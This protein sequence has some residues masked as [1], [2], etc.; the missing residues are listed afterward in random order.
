[1]DKFTELTSLQYIKWLNYARR[2]LKIKEFKSNG[3]IQNVFAYE[4][5]LDILTCA[6]LAKIFGFNTLMWK[7]PSDPFYALKLDNEGKEIKTR[8]LHFKI[9]L[10]EKN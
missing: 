8:V 3:F 2:N 7:K 6:N 5:P 4:K 9:G 1:M 10:I